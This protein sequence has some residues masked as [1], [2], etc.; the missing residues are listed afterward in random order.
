MLKLIFEVVDINDN[1]PIFPN[2][3]LSETIS[4][5]AGRGE[6]FSV[7]PATDKDSL[8]F[9]VIRYFLRD[10]FGGLFDIS[11]TERANHRE[12]LVTFLLNII[13]KYWIIDDDAK[14]CIDVFSW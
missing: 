14:V 13:F 2:T 8:K 3:V 10:T 1:H 9:G 6:L 11:F 5:G 7:R 12:V 4:E